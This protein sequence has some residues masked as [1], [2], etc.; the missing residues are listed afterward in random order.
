MSAAA[1]PRWATVTLELALFAALAAFGLAMWAR[2]FVSPPTARFAAVLA[3]A[4]LGGWALASLAGSRIRPALRLPLALGCAA[5][6]LAAALVAVGLPVRLLGPE[7]WDELGA[8]LRDGFAGIEDT[9]L[10][11]RGPDVWPRLTLLLGAPL[12]V[13]LAVAAAFWPGRSS[14]RNGAGRAGR[15]AAL[16]LLVALY[17]V[18][19]TLDSPG[20]ELLWGIPLLIL[21]AAWLWLPSLG[22][23]AAAATIGAVAGVA[24]LALPLASALES[25][26]AWLDYESWDVFAA[27]EQVSFEWDHGYGPLDWPQVG[28]S[29][30]SIQSRRPLYWKTSVLDRFDGFTWQRATRDDA[31]AAAEIA[32]RAT[33]PGARELAAAHPQWV[34]SAVFEVLGLESGLMVGTGVPLSAAGIEGG[35]ASSD[36]TVVLGADPLVRGDVYEITAY[37]PQPSPRLMRAAPQRYPRGGFADATLVGLPTAAPG[38]GA[39]LAPAS[40]PLRVP[41]WGRPA[42]DARA[43]ILASEYAPVYLLARRLT[44]GQPT[45]YDAV[46]AI[47]THL[48][49]NYDYSPNADPATY[50]LASFLLED[51]AGYCQHFSGAMALMLR[52]TGIPSRVVTGFAPGSYEAASDSFVVRDTDAHSWVEVFFPEIGWVTFDPTPTAAPAAAQTLEAGGPVA[53]R[54]DGSTQGAGRREDIEAAAEGGVLPDGVGDDG[55]GVPVAVVTA[56]LLGALALAGVLVTLRR[57]R[58]LSSPRADLVQSR[59]LRDALATLGWDVEP[60]A[61]LL[62]IERRFDR[63]GRREVGAYARALRE[64]RFSPGAR[65]LPGAADRRRLRRALARGGGARARLR[66]LRAIPPGGPAYG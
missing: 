38:A 43:A 64:H 6:V 63:A 13:S 34:Q 8:N 49:D 66:A 54:P 62:G 11:Y 42:A 44:E 5:I 30:L 56:A 18:A 61:T 65:A 41:T 25:D 15:V 24:V 21:A 60:G 52:M 57:R 32:A 40:D 22:M 31:L 58:R 4:I 10:P 47:Q 39:A 48:R 9:A 17:A 28:T 1:R 55:G 2:L 23:R 50:P 27:P 37:N 36:G 20:A 3:I 19:T 46:T 7:N 35:I 14:R 12:L 33:E 29:L 26:R 59:E 16:V 53:V 51:G 45:V